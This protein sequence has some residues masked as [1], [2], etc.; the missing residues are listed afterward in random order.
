MT[1]QFQG[2]K[3]LLP[4]KITLECMGEMFFRIDENCNK[5]K[6]SIPGGGFEKTDNSLFETA[7]RELREET[8][9]NLS[10]TT[11]KDPVICSFHYPFFE[12][13]TFMFEDDS[14]FH[15]PERFC[16]EFS[17]IKF[18]SLKDIHQYKLAFGVRKEIKKFLISFFPLAP[19]SGL[20]LK[21]A[22]KAK[23]CQNRSFVRKQNMCSK[24]RF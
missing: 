17:E 16:Y 23:W 10:S 5:G 20:R 1:T 4:G 7:I 9:I 13:I 18:I 21:S 2:K 3:S 11:E 24:E 14:N 8:G 22:L 19:K 12:W 6:W 15:V